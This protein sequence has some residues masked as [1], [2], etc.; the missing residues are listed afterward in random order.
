[1]NTGLDI[2]EMI[3]KILGFDDGMNNN[4]SFMVKSANYSDYS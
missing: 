3:D 4:D 1:V 2:I